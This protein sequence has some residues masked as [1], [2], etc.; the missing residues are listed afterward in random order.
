LI[1]ACGSDSDGPSLIGVGGEGG[2]NAG[3]GSGGTGTGT[4]G[5]VSNNGGSAPI[6]PIGD[7]GTGGTEPTYQEQNLIEFRVAP[8]DV[9]LQVALGQSEEIEY[10]AFGRFASDPQTE[11]ELTERTVFYVPDNYLVAGFPADGD[12]LL[13][14]R[15][16]ADS[17]D[18]RQRGG[19][20]TVRAQAA[21]TDG[22]ISTATTSLN[23]QLAGTLSPP[24][25]SPQATPALPENPAELFIGTTIP[26]RAPILAYPN[27]GVLLP[28]NLGRLEVH[29][30][31]G[32]PENTLFEV[33]FAS[34]TSELVY[35]TRC[36]S[37]AEQFEPGACALV[38]AGEEFDYLASSNQGSGP[39][40]LSVR[41]S[42]E[43]GNLGASEVFQIEFA[44]E[45]I[46]GAVYYY[47]TTSN[48]SSIVRFD[49]TGEPPFQG[50]ST[51]EVCGHHLHTAPVA[52]SQR[53]GKPVP[54]ALETLLLRCLAK[55]PDQ[56]PAD[57]RELHR[58]LRECAAECPW[59][60]DDARAYER[61]V[62]TTPPG[63]AV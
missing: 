35:F 53:L 1:L 58:S 28:P 50:R 57:A 61:H 19:T 38:I 10:R 45:R 39:V 9:V 11:V 7:G 56:R 22:S 5:N 36:D 24:V 6:F 63:V 16:P 23:V 13:S 31:P 47:W 55:R 26:S 17:S 27:D 49:F 41:G 62:T 12:N 30:Q 37:D 2:A 14:T 20:L 51:V 8:A 29:F 34:A 48:G 21:N 59:S 52:P 15:L 42:D 18:A 46:D 44:A 60:S 43:S 32:A 33:K 3:G 25:G 40:A 4:G 54:T